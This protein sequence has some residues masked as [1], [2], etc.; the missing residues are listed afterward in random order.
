MNISTSSDA[1]G[2]GLEDLLYHGGLEKG[3]SC[4]NAP[5]PR[6]CLDLWK[7]AH[8]ILSLQSR[9]SSSNSAKSGGS[10]GVGEKEGPLDNRLMTVSGT[11]ASSRIKG[12]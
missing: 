7:K 12:L 1:A 9:R 8:L 6:S 5:L 2:A 10:R 4:D 11:G 3:V